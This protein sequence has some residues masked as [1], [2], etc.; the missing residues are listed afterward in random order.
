MS[1]LF[2]FSYSNSIEDTRQKDIRVYW[3]IPTFQCRPH[4]INFTVLT[5]KFG[6]IQNKK[7]DFQGNKIAILYHPGSFPAIIYEKGKRILRNGGVPQAGNL[8]EH[9]Q[10]FEKAVEELIPDPGFSG[11]YK[12]DH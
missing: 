3:N 11:M 10:A 5:E 8:T 6:I 4:K 12:K 7:D 2:F 9:I 1:M